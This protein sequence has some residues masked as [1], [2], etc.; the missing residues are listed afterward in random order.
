MLLFLRLFVMKLDHWDIH[1]TNDLFETNIDLMDDLFEINIAQMDTELL[2]TMGHVDNEL[3][4]NFDQVDKKLLLNLDQVDIVDYLVK[5]VVLQNR[6][7]LVFVFVKF[8]LT[9]HI[10]IYI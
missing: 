9:S 5:I 4:L 1:L 2:I 10:C 6:K 3:F 7:H 8:S